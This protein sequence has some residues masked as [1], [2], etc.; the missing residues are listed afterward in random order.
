MKV[1]KTLLIAALTLP[2]SALSYAEDGYLVVLK[3]FATPTLKQGQA[4]DKQFSQLKKQGFSPYIIKTDA[5]PPL[6]KGL[7]ALVLGEFDKQAAT[8]KQTQVKTWVKDAY[9]RK[10]QLPEARAIDEQFAAV[11]T[12]FNNEKDCFVVEQYPERGDYGRDFCIGKQG[13]AVDIAYGD[14]RAFVNINGEEFQ[15]E[16]WMGSDGFPFVVNDYPLTWI[17]RADKLRQPV[18]VSLV[19]GTTDV[20]GNDHN[21]RYLITI[22]GKT[23][24]PVKK[25]FPVKGLDT[26]AAYLRDGA[27]EALDD[28]NTSSEDSVSP[29]LQACLDDNKSSGWHR[30]VNAN[31]CE[32][33]DYQRQLIKIHQQIDGAYRAL[34][35]LPM[36]KGKQA[37]G[38]L[39]KM[40]KAW[41]QYRDHKCQLFQ[42]LQLPFRRAQQSNC[43]LETTKNYLEEQ[44]KLLQE[45]Q[46]TLADDKSFI[47]N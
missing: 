17:Y 37:T 38:S 45:I 46:G 28:E 23:L 15:G 29:A 41:Q 3:S 43:E 34:L 40:D 6:K 18:A 13:Y 26:V 33:Q 22:N 10:V 35:T 1:Y 7:W 2:L 44:K 31:D 8:D 42:A 14:A 20:N 16:N 27:A 32:I 5:Y 9:I 19:I 47:E 39:K 12:Y 36:H 25:K 11:D 24:T 21:D 4:I 30:I